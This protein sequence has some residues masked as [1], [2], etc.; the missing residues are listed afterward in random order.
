MSIN[1]VEKNILG[2]YYAEGKLSKEVLDH[3]LEIG[4]IDVFDWVEISSNSIT[5]IDLNKEHE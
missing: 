5:I 4:E 2:K 3:M 1:S